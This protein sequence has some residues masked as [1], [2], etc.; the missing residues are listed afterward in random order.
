MKYGK[1]WGTKPALQNVLCTLTFKL[2]SS[3]YLCHNNMNYAQKFTTLRCFMPK[4]AGYE[5]SRNGGR[6]GLCLPRFWHYQKQN[7][8]LQNNLFLTPVTS[9]FWNFQRHCRRKGWDDKHL[10]FRN[11]NFK[12]YFNI[13]I[14]D[15]YVKDLILIKYLVLILR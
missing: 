10:L 1:D 5:Q 2:F 8:Y 11:A 6:W 14:A 7:I 13:S 12:V 15:F 4:T 3:T 9:D